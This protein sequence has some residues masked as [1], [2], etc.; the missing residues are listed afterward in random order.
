MFVKILNVHVYCL[1]TETSRDVSEMRKQFEK[2]KV[3]FKEITDV[4]DSNLLIDT[5]FENAV[6][7]SVITQ[8]ISTTETCLLSLEDLQRLLLT[9]CETVICFF[10]EEAGSSVQHMYSQLAEF[11]AGYSQSKKKFEDNLRKESRLKAAAASKA[12]VVAARSAK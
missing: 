5:D 7:E 1:N 2:L 3:L 10:G 4:K 11:T 9:R 8:F 12:A 6:N